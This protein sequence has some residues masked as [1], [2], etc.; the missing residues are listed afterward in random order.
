VN[1]LLVTRV[2]CSRVS[3]STQLSFL[4]EQT[5]HRNRCTLFHPS[6]LADDQITECDQKASLYSTNYNYASIAGPYANHL[7][8]ASD[9]QPHQHLITNSLQAGCSA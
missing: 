4:C 2:T 3:N 1:V 6:N 8:L 5:V 9:R 7:H